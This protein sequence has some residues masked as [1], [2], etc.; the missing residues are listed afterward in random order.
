MEI[1]AFD[2]EPVVLPKDD[3]TWKFALGAN[4]ATEGVVVRLATD[5]AEGYGYASATAHMESRMEF[6]SLM[7]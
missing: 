5:S 2:L 3:P 7:L 1:I 4:P 6:T